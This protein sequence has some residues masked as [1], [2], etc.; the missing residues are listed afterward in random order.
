MARHNELLRAALA[1][2][3]AIAAMVFA[4]APV[5]AQNQTSTTFQVT[6]TAPAVCSV[7]SNNLTFGNYTGS[8]VD[9]VATT[10]VTCNDQ[11]TTWEI[12]FDPGLHSTTSSCAN[13]R[14]QHTTTSTSFLE[15]NIYRDAGRLDTLGARLEAGCVTHSG[16][17]TANRNVFGRI[18]AGQTVT[19]GSYADTV[20]ATIYW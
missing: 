19:T 4:V 6:A 11:T 12:G 18:T 17:G 3:A 15:Y 7:V 16:T 13:R 10:S 20:T 2:V 9:A 5:P 1:P 8:Q 14:M